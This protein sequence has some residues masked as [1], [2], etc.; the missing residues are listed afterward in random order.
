VKCPYCG[1]P[2]AGYDFGD[3]L[4]CPHCGEL[5]CIDETAEGLASGNEYEV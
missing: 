3:V 4:E 1:A 2:L 5:V